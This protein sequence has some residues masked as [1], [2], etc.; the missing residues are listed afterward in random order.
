MRVYLNGRWRTQAEPTH[1]APST[2][3]TVVILEEDGSSLSRVSMACRALIRV[4]QARACWRLL[5]ISGSPN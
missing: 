1:P 3:H 2:P 4:N 5:R